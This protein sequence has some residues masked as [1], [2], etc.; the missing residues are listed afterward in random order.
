MSRHGN[1]RAMASE[2][3]SSL[4]LLT[5]AIWLPW[6]TYRSAAFDV[7]F[8]SGGWGAVLLACGAGSV[9]LVAVSL[10][11][12]GAGIHWLQ[13]LLGA[14]ALICSVAI[15][16][17]KIGDANRTVTVHPGYS[18]TSYGIGAGLALAASVALVVSSL[19]QLAAHK[20]PERPDAGRIADPA[21]MR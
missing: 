2:V 5:A 9:A 11:W 18:T 21:A 8:R 19:V 20:V 6:A 12:S 3:L 17:A 7:D 13:L 4:V 1:I 15:A 10:L 16:L 14:T